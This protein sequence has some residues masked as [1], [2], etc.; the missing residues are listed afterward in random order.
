MQSNRPR[1]GL[2]VRSSPN[3]DPEVR[4]ACLEYIQWIRQQMEFPIRVV[5]YLKEDYRNN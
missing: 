5:I 2:R 3:V 4:R 1:K